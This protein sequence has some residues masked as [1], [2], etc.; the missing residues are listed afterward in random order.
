MVER[1]PHGPA[2]GTEVKR[3]LWVV[4]SDF[5]DRQEFWQEVV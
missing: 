4:W 3:E 5:G 2:R 1:R